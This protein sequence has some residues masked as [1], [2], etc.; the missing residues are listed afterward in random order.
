MDLIISHCP[1]GI[2]LFYTEIVGNCPLLLFIYLL[3]WQL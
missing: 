2:G 1:S 3:L